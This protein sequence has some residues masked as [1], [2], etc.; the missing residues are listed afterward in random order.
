MHGLRAQ[1]AVTGQLQLSPLVAF[2]A[3]GALAYRHDLDD[4]RAIGFTSYG[5]Q[6]VM[7]E[8]LM[9]LSAGVDLRASYGATIRDG[10]RTNAEIVFGLVFRHAP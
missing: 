2:A 8:L 4:Y 5:S 10:E 1:L 6:L 7:L 9:S 3:T